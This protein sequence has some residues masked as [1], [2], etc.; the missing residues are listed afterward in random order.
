M[1]LI[2][3]F[4]KWEAVGSAELSSRENVKSNEIE[5]QAEL[6]GIAGFSIYKNQDTLTA[7]CVR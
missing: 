6:N 7:V 4:K 3:L 2:S 5:P 1:L